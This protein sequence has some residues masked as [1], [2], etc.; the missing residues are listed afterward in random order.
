[1]KRFSAFFLFILVVSVSC[2]QNSNTESSS[3]PI[4]NQAQQN[5]PK[6]LDLTMSDFKKS[7]EG[8]EGLQIIDV[9]TPGEI[10]GGKIGNALEVDYM[11]PKFAEKIKAL[12]LDKSKPV[13][14]Y[15]AAGGR[16][17]RAV[18]VLAENGYTTTF[19]LLGG[20]NAY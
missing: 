4:D 20:Y 13:V 5:K 17:A 3:T 1:M 14:V 9:R 6:V 10:A 2:A 8:K 12:K 7:F 19:T 18:Q 11:D 16:S 15:C